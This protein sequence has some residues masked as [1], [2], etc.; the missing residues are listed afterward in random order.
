VAKKT[1]FRDD[2]QVALLKFID[3]YG[4]ELPKNHDYQEAFIRTFDA[5]CV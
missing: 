1:M 2:F 3:G 5:L 4:T